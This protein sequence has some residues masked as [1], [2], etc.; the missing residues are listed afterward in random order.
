MHRTTRFSVLAWLMPGSTELAKITRAISQIDFEP[1]ISD[2]LN[3]PFHSSLRTCTQ[4]G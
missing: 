1:G 2:A 4:T 3:M